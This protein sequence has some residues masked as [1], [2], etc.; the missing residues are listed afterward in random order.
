MS[1][2]GDEITLT[3]P[4]Q[5]PYYRVAH[6]VVGGLAL[7][8]DLT[9]ENLEDLQLA[10]EG[11]LDHRREEDGTV[12]VQVRVE[13]ET[14]TT[15]VGPFPLNTLRTEL[16]RDAAETGVTLARL[17]ATVVDGYEIGERDGREWIALTKVVR[18]SG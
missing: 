9:F 8:L 18:G 1:R 2:V 4:R 16:E 15:T 7:R 14:L 13:D 6:L 5:R 12:T 11:L 10:L 17:L 3:L